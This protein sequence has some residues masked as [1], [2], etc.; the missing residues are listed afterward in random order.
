[1]IRF[2]YGKAVVETQ[3]RRGSSL[4][5]QGG[6]KHRARQGEQADSDDF[7]YYF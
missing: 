5:G 1:M 2:R 3:N 7:V 4:I 6:G